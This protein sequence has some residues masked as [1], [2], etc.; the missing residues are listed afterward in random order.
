MGHESE[1]HE[2]SFAYPYLFQIAHKSVGSRKSEV[3]KR[4]TEQVVATRL[5]TY[6]IPYL[7]SLQ[8]IWNLL[9]VHNIS[10]PAMLTLINH[11]KSKLRTALSSSFCE[12]LARCDLR[13]LSTTAPRHYYYYYLSRTTRKKALSQPTFETSRPNRSFVSV[14][15]ICLDKKASP[16]AKKSDTP[17]KAKRKFLPPKAA[18]ELT[19]KARTF[20]KRLLE[21]PPRTDVVGTFVS[22]C[23]LHDGVCV[24]GLWMGLK[25]NYWKHTFFGAK[26]RHGLDYINY[27]LFHLWYQHFLGGKVCA[28]KKSHL[29]LLVL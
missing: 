7:L 11:G 6:S 8:L 16:F 22:F 25:W 12:S 4:T 14:T 20:F 2:K 9:L 10:P 1:S 13:P 24:C 26:N 3:D 5:E 28:E 15:G 29:L 21:N 23:I 17:K 19:P 18:V 27:L